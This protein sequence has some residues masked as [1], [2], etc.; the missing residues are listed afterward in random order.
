MLT[1]IGTGASL[2]AGPAQHARRAARAGADDPRRRRPRAPGAVA[3]RARAA[4][5]AAARSAPTSAA[6][7]ASTP[8]TAAGSAG[9][10]TRRARL[11]QVQPRP[12]AQ[13]RR[14]SSPRA[15]CCSRPA[16]SC[17]G[18]TVGASTCAPAPTFVHDWFAI[19]VLL[20][21]DRPHRVRPPRP[22][23]ARAACS[24]AGCRPVGPAATIRGGTRR[25]PGSGPTSSRRS[26]RRTLRSRLGAEPRS[27]C[28]RRRVTPPRTAG[29]SLT[30]DAH[31]DPASRRAPARRRPVRLGPVEGPH[32]GPRRASRPP[33][34]ATS[35]RATGATACGRS[36]AGSA[37]ASPTLF[38]LPDGYEVLL[39]NGGSTA[40]W[41]A[42][43]FG[44]IE[45]RSAAPRDRRVLVEVRRGHPRRAVPRRPRSWSST[46]P[47]PAARSPPTRP[48][49][50]TR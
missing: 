14:S 11:G 27:S 39:G 6:S 4:A 7:T 50:S 18:P 41:D 5:G 32:R 34:P 20:A 47:A 31:R 17:A 24:A 40:F 43:A 3:R 22:D 1:L 21:V 44:L 29:P 16:R 12:E 10:P 37:R 26:A 48:S 38:G 33:A 9:A 35:A 45:E 13:R 15:S 30:A 42:L 25:S 28:A 19:G 49:T 8:R 46:R 2:Y 36:C 23:G